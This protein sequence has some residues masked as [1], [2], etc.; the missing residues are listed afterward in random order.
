MN[1]PINNELFDTRD[2]IE[3]RDFLQ[4]SL[5]DSYNEYLED[6]NL[7]ADEDEQEELAENYEDIVL[8]DGFID[9]YNTELEHCKDITNF[10]EELGEYFPDFGFGETLIHESYFE[11]YCE[12]LVKDCG[13]IHRDL[14]N[15]IVINWKETA[16]NI[17]VDYTEFEFEGETY[18]AR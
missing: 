7:N 17:K 2:L 14:P 10:C 16:D 6:Y 15:W 11:E 18:Y 3:Y 8:L 9:R 4:S 12:D 5:V 13:Y 1:N